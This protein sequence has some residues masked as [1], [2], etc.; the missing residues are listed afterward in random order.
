MLQHLKSVPALAIITMSLVS[1]PMAIAA[2][3][4][5]SRSGAG[6][7]AQFVQMAIRPGLS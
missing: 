2:T 3:G 1:G 5:T 6:A 7:D 4:Q